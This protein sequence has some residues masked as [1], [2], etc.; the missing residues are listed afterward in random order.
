MKGPTSTSKDL[1]V[2]TNFATQDGMILHLRTDTPNGMHIAAFDCS[3]IS[4]YAEENERLFIGNPKINVQKRVD[5]FRLKIE[6][7]IKI[8]SGQNFQQYV[9]AFYVFDAMISNVRDKH[10]D[11]IKSSDILILNK[12]IDRKGEETQDVNQY[13]VDTFD[14]FL[15]GKTKMHI[16]MF[17]LTEEYKAISHLLMYSVVDQYE[18]TKEDSKCNLLNTQIFGIF[19]NL[20]QVVINATSL[21]IDEK[22]M[23]NEVEFFRSDPLSWVDANKKPTKL[24]YFSY[25]FDLSSFLVSI[26]SAK[27]SITYII[28][29][30]RD[31]KSQTSWCSNILDVSLKQTY[32]N[33]GW[34]IQY[35]TEREKILYTQEE[36]VIVDCLIVSNMKQF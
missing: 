4:N 18:E 7:I 33:A 15:Y 36:E 24:K 31:P 1:S 27:S 11:S 6:S 20:N 25:K 22:K 19:P 23:K 28:R 17:R 2:A 3:W 35:K 32:I 21:D 16:N 12:F 5:F 9:H 10:I 34:N 29:A 26:K 14:L 13:I 8:E 30:H